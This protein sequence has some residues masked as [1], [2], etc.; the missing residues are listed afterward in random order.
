LTTIK[1]RMGKMFLGGKKVLLGCKADY[2]DL[3]KG[4]KTPVLRIRIRD[5]VFCDSWIRDPG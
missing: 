5:S 4:F 2:W 1:R 3:K